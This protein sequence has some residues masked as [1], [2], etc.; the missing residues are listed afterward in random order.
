MKKV[1]AVISLLVIGFVSI[2]AK[3]APG[4]R[5]Y[6]ARFKYESS[7]AIELLKNADGKLLADSPEALTLLED[8]GYWKETRKA[9]VFNF[10]TELKEKITAHYNYLNR[11]FKYEAGDIVW[12]AAQGNTELTYGVGRVNH[13]A[14]IVE[15]A[16]V[17]E[18]D[19]YLVDVYVDGPTKMSKQMG[20]LYDGR[21]GEIIY[22]S[23]DYNLEKIRRL[24]T[25][26]ELDTLNSPG[27]S[28]PVDSQGE[29]LD[30]AGD[31]IWN[32]KL[33]AFKDKMAAAD[34]E[35]DFREIP[36]QIQAKQQELMLQIFKHFKMNRNSPSQNGR[37]IGPRSCGGGVCFDQALVLNYAIQGVGQT[38]GIKSFNLNGTTVNP[39]GGHGF[40]RYDLK[41]MSQDVTFDRVWS[42]EIWATEHAKQ[43]NIVK[44][45]GVPQLDIKLDPAL[46]YYQGVTVRST[47]WT[48]ISDPGW[49]DYGVTP[50]FFARVPLSQALSP[51][52]VD[53]NRAVHG[54]S[55]QRNLV[56]VAEQLK[57]KGPMNAFVPQSISRLDETKR[58]EILEALKL[59]RDLKSAAQKVL[60][61]AAVLEDASGMM[62]SKLF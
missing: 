59:E 15:H 33:E 8:M 5:D 40:V 47:T 45:G 18:T 44:Q 25:K 37:G 53:S 36:S 46:A 61:G 55:S 42:Y 34:F 22:Y 9:G 27:S 7:E 50:D 2:F 35:I 12:V 1:V 3:A 16:R 58:T 41:T 6:F 24:M 10:S 13:R 56:D 29:K 60:V 11:A 19:M 57:A 30:W 38:L 49:A 39:Q 4:P 54:L 14:Q 52:P 23:K 20:T 32:D 43:K 28:L 51:L 31:K 62:C 48:G 26:T 21:Q 17:N